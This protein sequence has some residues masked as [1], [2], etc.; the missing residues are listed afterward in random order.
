[1]RAIAEAV[2]PVALSARALGRWM[3][4]SPS[5][6]IEFN[7]ADGRQHPEILHILDSAI[8][9]QQRAAYFPA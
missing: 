8:E 4:R 2:A 5:D 3:T 1:M 9:T 7:D 6:V